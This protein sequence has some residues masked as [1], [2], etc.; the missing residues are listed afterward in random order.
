MPYCPECGAE[1]RKG[2]EECADCGVEL[3][4]DED[5]LFPDDEEEAENEDEEVPEDD[6]DLVE[7]FSGPPYAAN[8]LAN[9]LRKQSVGA[10]VQ[11]DSD[12][13]LIAPTESSVF[14]TEN[15]YNLHDEVI[16]QCMELV[17]AEDPE[18]HGEAF[19]DEEVV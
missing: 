4:E 17:E 1:Y 10:T 11:S 13:A 15:D 9:A 18:D 5:E 19:E 3:V 6:S 8:L 14:V 12:N 7:I 16:Q 2:Y